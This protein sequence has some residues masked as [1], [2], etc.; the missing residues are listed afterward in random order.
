MP[1][2][3]KLRITS[4]IYFQCKSP[5]KALCYTFAEKLPLLPAV[6]TD[7]LTPRG[8]KYTEWRGGC[9]G[10]LGVRDFPG[11]RE[12]TDVIKADQNAVYLTWFCIWRRKQILSSSKAEKWKINGT[13]MPAK[14]NITIT[15]GC[16]GV[17]TPS[18]KGEVMHLAREA[19]KDRD[20]GDWLLACWVV[21]R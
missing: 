10:C 14:S 1:V 8:G 18:S 5:P 20:R 6:G 12:Q 9:L 21:T 19:C 3:C 2:S 16:L 15:V 11:W 4:N 7:S 17:C 13:R